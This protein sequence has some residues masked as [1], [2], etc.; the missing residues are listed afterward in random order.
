[1]LG[2]D[3]IGDGPGVE[4]LGEVE[5][6]EFV[7]DAVDLADDAV[8]EEVWG[9]VVAEALDDGYAECEFAWRGVFQERVDDFR[10]EVDEGW[11]EFV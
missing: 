11:R 4:T 1:M 3:A 8:G 2:L 10:A 7:R 9:A 6:V 5:F